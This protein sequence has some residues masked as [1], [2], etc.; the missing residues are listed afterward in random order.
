MHWAITRRTRLTLERGRQIRLAPPCRPKRAWRN[1]RAGCSS[2]LPVRAAGCPKRLRTGPAPRAGVGKPATSPHPHPD[3]HDRAGSRGEPDL[4]IGVALLIVTVAVPEPSVFDDAPAWLTFGVVPAYVA[5]ALGGG[6][7][8]DYPPNR[9][10]AALG[11][12]RAQA[13]T[14]DDERNTFLAPWR[15]AT[16]RPH[17]VGH[18]HGRVDDALRSDQHAVHP[19]VPRSR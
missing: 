16:V 1:A 15:I 7:L 13:P 10:R 18:R 3:H 19:A 14:R 11:D 5:L 17:P 6:H 8:L 4:G 2:G 9:A 12:R